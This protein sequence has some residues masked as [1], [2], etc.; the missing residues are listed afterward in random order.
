M[1]NRISRENELENFSVK[2]V[3]L[4][5]VGSPDIID[6]IHK[7]LIF[8]AKNETKVKFSHNGVIVEIEL[9]SLVEKLYEKWNKELKQK[10][11]ES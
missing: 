6:C 10:V 8:A 3:F 11:K 9:D 7:A 5:V 2:E 1:K 4:R